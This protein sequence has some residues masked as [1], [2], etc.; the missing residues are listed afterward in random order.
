MRFDKRAARFGHVLN[1]L[2]VSTRRWAPRMVRR[3]RR[4]VKAGGWAT[5][6]YAYWPGLSR[7][8][9]IEQRIPGEPHI[10]AMVEAEQNPDCAMHGEATP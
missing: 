3:W 2:T 8:Q 9:P 1:P 6:P 7:A 4:S 5:R 10:P